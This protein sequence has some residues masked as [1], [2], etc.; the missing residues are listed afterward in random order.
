[1]SGEDER[2]LQSQKERKGRK[3]KRGKKQGLDEIKSSRSS[4]G[5][6][7]KKR[8]IVARHRETKLLKI[9]RWQ[10]RGEC[11]VI[12]DPNMQDSE[13]KERTKS[14]EEKV[15]GGAARRALS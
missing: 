5:S 12:E 8:L 7:S 10:G 13:T 3:N 9:S 4:P 15:G 2:L 14:L 11:I 6:T 1:L